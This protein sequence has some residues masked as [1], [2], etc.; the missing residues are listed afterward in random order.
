VGRQV[1]LLGVTSHA[2]RQYL[3]DRREIVGPGEALSANPELAVMRLLRRPSLE[4]HHRGHGV[5]GAEIGHVEALDPDGELGQPQG[6][7]KLSQC[8]DPLL[9]A[10]LP[11]QP[12]LGESEACVAIGEL[13]QPPLVSPL[14]H[15]HL[16]RAAPPGA[17]R[18]GEELGAVAQ[19]R[20]DHDEPRDRRD[21]RV[22]LGDE[23]LRHLP[24]VALRPV[25]EVEA[26]ALGE[27][28]VAHLEDL[29]VC[30]AAVHRDPDQVGRADSLAR[31]PLP[32]EQGPDGC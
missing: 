16:D 8:L 12:V 7:L 3:L 13:P 20:P 24:L 27:H 19:R 5:L 15:P 2:A 1:G 10:A 9:A 29:G 30:V 31:H 11:P 32:L 23:L 28:S 4:H 21:G 22:V 25:V 18:L 26:L 14:G 6:L 17:E